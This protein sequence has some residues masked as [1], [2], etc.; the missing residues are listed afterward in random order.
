MRTYNPAAIASFKGLQKSLKQLLEVHSYTLDLG[1][2]LG[3]LKRSKA[4]TVGFHVDAAGYHPS[5]LS[6]EEWH[7]IAGSYKFHLT[8]RY[9]K[10]DV[11]HSKAWFFKKALLL[12]SANI[13]VREARENLNFWCWL[14]GLDAAPMRK[15]L[16]GNG[17]A[18]LL[19]DLQTTSPK[20]RAAPIAT[21]KEAIGQNKIRSLVIATPQPPNKTILKK[22]L[23]NTTKDGACVFFLNVESHALSKLPGNHKWPVY[24]L[25]S[26]DRSVGLHG[27]ALYAEWGTGAKQGAVLY[28]GSANF[29]QAAYCGDNIEA[30][31][32]FKGE[33]PA[34]VKDLQDALLVL[35]GRAGNHSGKE[36]WAT[37]RFWGRWV[38]AEAGTGETAPPPFRAEEDLDLAEFIDS[39]RAKHNH[40]AFPAKYGSKLI[41]R[42][43]L[44]ASDRKINIWS[45][46]KGSRRRFSGVVWCPDLTLTITLNHRTERTINIPPLAGIMEGIQEH[47]GLLELLLTQTANSSDKS[48]TKGEG[49]GRDFISI[50]GNDPRVLFPWDAIAG[51]GYSHLLRDKHELKRALK[52]IDEKL[53]EP[54]NAEE[55]HRLRKLENIAFTLKCLLNLKK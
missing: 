49:P 17:P 18:T 3:L 34:M 38:K 33:G 25:I 36:T 7:E 53:H 9:K 6:A 10:G 29:T 51:N 22:L 23:S 1:F 21:I 8:P 42:A 43:E 19:W 40:L 16:H 52:S 39:L 50:Y 12:G 46:R 15:L 35:L 20:L 47:A 2:A 26:Q 45:A 31:I 4:K 14:P 48:T 13:S 55:P 5:E 54:D 30:G 11:F 32:V 28:I 24:N 44:S 37:E 41:T 27:K